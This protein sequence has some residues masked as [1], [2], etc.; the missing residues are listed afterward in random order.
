MIQ[1]DIFS[2]VK[3]VAIIGGK[4]GSNGLCSQTVKVCNVLQV[5]ESDIMIED[6]SGYT[7]RVAIVPKNVCVP[8][9]AQANQL[10]DAR[11]LEPAI[12]DLVYTLQRTDWKDKDMTKTVGILYEVKYE[13]GKPTALTLLVGDEFQT[14]KNEGILVLQTV[15]NMKK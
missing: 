6:P 11:T 9:V 1:D 7:P 3:Q 13:L 2:G 12:G 15:E 10:K 14:V 4:V 5:G 8:V